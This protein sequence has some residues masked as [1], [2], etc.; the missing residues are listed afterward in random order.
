MFY[1]KR[2][3]RY[4]LLTTG[5]AIASVLFASCTQ[6]QN[7]S[8]SQLVSQATTQTVKTKLLKVGSRNT[9]TE[10]V[11]RYIKTEIAPS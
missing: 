10:D 11:L 7:S 3:R 5:W 4:F 6:N 1:I 9:T 2:N 8:T